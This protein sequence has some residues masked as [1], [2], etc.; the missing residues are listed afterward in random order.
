[1]T[2]SSVAT[3]PLL[4]VGGIDAHK[5][6]HQ[7]VVLNQQGVL[8]GDA[9]FAASTAGYRQLHAW[10]AS[11][12]PIDRVGIESTGSYAAGLTRFLAAAGVA[13]VEVNQ[14]HRHTRA[15][16]GKSDVIDAEAAARKV[17]SSEAAVTPKATTGVV[18]SIRLLRS[19]RES[20]VK[21]RAAALT[22]LQS[23]LVTAP[24]ELRE[25]LTGTARAITAASAKLRPDPDRL[26][27]PTQAAKLALR[28]LARRI[29][30]LDDEIADLDGC[31]KPL[32]AQ[33]APT[34]LS[35]TGIGTNHAA[36][37]LVT[38]GQNIDRLTTEAKFARICGV[39]PIPVSSG[40]TH[41][42]RLHRGG[43]RQANRALH[44]IVVCRLRY[45]PDTRT[46]LA[47]RQA[48]GL[49]KLDAIRCL[50]RYVARQVFNDLKTDLRRL[51]DL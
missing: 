25:Q 21:D 8:L 30:D 13:V 2:A 22:Q 38:A 29:G 37:L 28:S 10:L 48:E 46:Y 51:D 11:F 33:A 15:R 47:R 4:V 9:V 24:A 43:D 42:M 36:Q 34:L 44:L 16:R 3:Q 14:P 32:V 31:L 41:R 49:S 40:K 20:A 18:E 17:L 6:T 7:V 39:A 35:R 50:K 26:D 23:L 1:M 19:A 5:D 45:D 12:G 27:Q